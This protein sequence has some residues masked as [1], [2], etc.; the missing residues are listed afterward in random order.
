MATELD[1]SPEVILQREIA[2]FNQIRD[3]RG[4]HITAIHLQPPGKGKQEFVLEDP[5]KPDVNVQNGLKD[6]A[7]AYQAERETALIAE[8]EASYRTLNAETVAMFEGLQ[9]LVKEGAD[10]AAWLESLAKLS[11]ALPQMVTEKEQFRAEHDDDPVIP[12]TAALQQLAGEIAE[13]QPP[14]FPLRFAL[15]AVEGAFRR[16]ES[17]TPAA[18]LQAWQA[19]EKLAAITSP[20]KLA[21]ATAVTIGWLGRNKASPLIPDVMGELVPAA[22]AFRIAIAAE[23]APDTE[24]MIAALGDFQQSLSAIATPGFDFSTP[25]NRGELARII[26]AAEAI[27]KLDAQQVDTVAVE[28][29][30]RRAAA[31][32]A[33]ICEGKS[34]E[35]GI[36]VWLA[37][38]IHDVWKRHRSSDAG[39]KRAYSIFDVALR[40]ELDAIPRQTHPYLH[41]QI[42]N[43]RAYLDT[44]KPVDILNLTA[45]SRLS[46][47]DSEKRARIDLVG[48]E[49]A[50]P[51]SQINGGSLQG[52]AQGG[53]KS[54]VSSDER[55]NVDRLI[56]GFVEQ[57]SAGSHVATVG[58][59]DIRKGG[60]VFQIP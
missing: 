54:V 11:S 5:E 49:T 55:A 37:A 40:K 32:T 33:S 28:I 47:Y 38:E 25:E 21:G 4:Q 10:R 23:G 43:L 13:Q 44:G 1:K 31:I 6:F 35:R 42:L 16:N 59:G 58:E 20:Q 15:F 36:M 50:S 45:D 18:L 14:N 51:A 24:K 9:L 48:R 52:R 7:R 57:G 2:D 19:G 17:V 22:G 27:A 3:I 46:L 34:E 60:D 53:E 56:Q 39:G 12:I 26:A 8:R 30:Q 41:E 29:Q